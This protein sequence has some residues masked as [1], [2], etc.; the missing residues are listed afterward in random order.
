MNLN[1]INLF[2]AAGRKI[3]GNKAWDDA[4]FSYM[5]QNLMNKAAGTLLAFPVHVF[6]NFTLNDIYKKDGYDA[7][8]QAMDDFLAGKTL[9]APEYLLDGEEI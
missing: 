9:K 4:R 7:A 8:K 2:H 3:F 1:L 6:V 5:C